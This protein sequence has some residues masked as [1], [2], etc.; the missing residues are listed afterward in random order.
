M[1][2]LGPNGSDRNTHLTGLGHATVEGPVLVQPESGPGVVTSAHL[3]T[4][5]ELALVKGKLLAGGNLGRGG[6]HLVE[7]GGLAGALGV[8][9]EGLANGLVGL[10]T[11][12]DGVEV[13]VA[14]LEEQVLGVG[15][16]GGPH[17]VTPAKRGEPM[18]V[19]RKM[20]CIQ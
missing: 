19:L 14:V 12:T 7:V 2:V 17:A 10:E 3:G 8:A 18:S 1:G 13:E 20:Q 5:T 4:D 9:G 11:A 16:V 6:V 15:G